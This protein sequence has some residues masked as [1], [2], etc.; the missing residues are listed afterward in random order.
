MK[1]AT[2]KQRHGSDHS[3]IRFPP[4]D[5]ALKID[6][7]P[8]QTVTLN[9]VTATIDEAP[10]GFLEI[11]NP[12]FIQQLRRLGFTPYCD[13]SFERLERIVKIIVPTEFQQSFLDEFS[14]R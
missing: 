12:D 14:G 4:P 9:A 3:R 11:H 10:N 1:M 6:L 13:N 2:A 7:R 5:P 8:G